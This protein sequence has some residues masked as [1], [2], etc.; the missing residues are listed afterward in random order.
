MHRRAKYSPKNYISFIVLRTLS[1]PLIY[2]FLL[3]IVK[4]HYKYA[5][6]TKSYILKIYIF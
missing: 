4:I 3:E 2:F 6:T 5:Q 1:F